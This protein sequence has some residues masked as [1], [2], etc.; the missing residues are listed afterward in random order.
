M[1]RI[2]ES[3]NFNWKDM[4]MN[5]PVRNMISSKIQPNSTISLRNLEFNS[6][7]GNF[8]QASPHSWI[9]Q[10]ITYGCFSLNKL[11]SQ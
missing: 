7:L 1:A 3:R 2:A 9:Q 11:L 4:S 6:V 5:V 10:D 8:F